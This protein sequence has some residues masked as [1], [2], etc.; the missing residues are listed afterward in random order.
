MRILN[1]VS[2][3]RTFMELKYQKQAD[4]GKNRAYQSNLYGIEICFVV[5]LPSFVAVPIEPLWNWNEEAGE[6]ELPEES[7]NRTFMELKF[8]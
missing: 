4:D 1:A 3:N 5:V 6:L 8:L 2:T 7:T